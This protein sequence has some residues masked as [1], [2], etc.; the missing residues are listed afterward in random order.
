MASMEDVTVNNRRAVL[1]FHGTVDGREVC[2]TMTL[3]I[4]NGRSRWF[5]NGEE[6]FGSTHPTL[7]ARAGHLM[8]R[9]LRRPVE[10]E[11]PLKYAFE[12]AGA[13]PGELHPS[14]F[15]E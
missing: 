15:V 10:A 2:G 12:V 14:Q 6:V 11:H 7:V 5:V 4:V 8:D 13:L 1:D 9:F 3:L